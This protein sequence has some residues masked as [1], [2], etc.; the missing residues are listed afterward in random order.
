MRETIIRCDECCKAHEAAEGLDRGVK[1]V[2]LKMPEPSGYR[3]ERD[4]CNLDCM[5]A[6]LQRQAAVGAKGHHV[7]KAEQ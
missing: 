6:W 3:E 7:P 1:L 4:F 5:W 2:T